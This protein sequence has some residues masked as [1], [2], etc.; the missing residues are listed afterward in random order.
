MKKLYLLSVWLFALS[1]VACNESEDLG[2]YENW[3]ARNEA[4]I[5]SLQQVFDAKTD[6]ELEALEY[7][8]NKKY[9][10][11]Y[12]KI[13]SAPDGERPFFTSTVF[14]YYRGMFI[15]EAVFGAAPGTAYYT[16]LYEQLTVFDKNTMKHGYDPTPF[17]SPALF[18]IKSFYTSSVGVVPAWADILEHMRVG[19]R[20]EVYIPWQAAYGAS[21][22]NNIPGYSTLIFD[23]ILYRI[24]EK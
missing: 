9:I 5:D 7:R 20:W 16:T 22:Y 6:P 23:I 10:I 8:R 2:K 11:F 19:E 24:D 1:F 21:G 13:V 18:N 14:C 3:Q 4:F 17:D 15:D 12:K